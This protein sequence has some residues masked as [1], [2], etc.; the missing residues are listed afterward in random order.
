ML[1]QSQSPLHVQK[2]DAK[3]LFSI[4]AKSKHLPS[5]RKEK[6]KEFHSRS[7]K[8]YHPLMLND[9]HKYFNST[10]A[11]KQYNTTLLPGV[12][13]F[14]LRMFCGAKYTRHTFTPI[15]KHY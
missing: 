1:T 15:I 10:N 7:E 14:A 2:P 5:R 9:A 4:M 3:T 11:K 8:E 6:K 13:P 12:N